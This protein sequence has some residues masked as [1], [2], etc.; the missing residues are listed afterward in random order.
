MQ[1]VRNSVPIFI[2]ARGALMDGGHIY[3]GVANA[4]PQVSPIAVYSDAALTVELSQPIRT[5]G[6]LAVDGVVPVR[7]FCAETDYSQRVTDNTG[8]LVDYSPSVFSDTDLFQAAS[9]ILDALVANG[10]PTT[11]GLTMLKLA[12]SAQLKTATGIP[13]CL[14]LSGGTLSGNT[15]HQGAG[16]EPY[17]NDPAMVDPRIFLTAAGG[18]DP[19]SGEGNIWLKK[20]AP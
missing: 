10:T 15:T 5:L 11:F 1:Q 2:D 6:G 20:V 16:T 12:N 19:T 7:M 3:I 18:A 4:D 9:S 13:D 14:P 8:S 17:W